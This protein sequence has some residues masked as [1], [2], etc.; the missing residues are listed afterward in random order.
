MN[1]NY[2]IIHTLEE[3][4]MGIFNKLKH[5]TSNI[6]SKNEEE[7]ITTTATTATMTAATT[8][9]MESS[10]H[11]HEKLPSPVR[12]RQH[13]VDDSGDVAA[14]AATK[15]TFALNKHDEAILRI[16]AEDLCSN[17]RVI[18]PEALQ[19]LSDFCNSTIVGTQ[20]QAMKNRKYIA[21]NDGV[22]CITQVMKQ[23]PSNP[24]ILAAGAAAL[25]N[26]MCNFPAACEKVHILGGAQTVI[27]AMKAYP[28]DAHM[29]RTGA[30][31]VLNF[32]TEDDVRKKLAVLLDG[33]HTI[34][35]A[36]KKHPDN[37]LLQKFAS[38]ALSVWCNEKAYVGLVAKTGGLS[39]A[40]I[41][42]ERH[43]DDPRTNMYTKIVIQALNDYFQY[44]DVHY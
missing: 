26:L 44:N 5:Q 9:I 1:Q 31:F 21:D 39:A 35:A 30:G 7:T 33:I 38:A 13:N 24:E 2:H 10:H 27:K 4:T 40:A 11:S 41:A 36:M 29:Q 3:I 15:A 18:I 42:L 8:S 16:L 12:H 37:I 14:G 28:N 43:G 17:D 23:N 19:M 32:I 34:L 6:M 22:G 20:I 25:G